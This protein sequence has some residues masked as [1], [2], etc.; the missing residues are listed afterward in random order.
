MGHSRIGDKEVDILI[1]I[2]E[3]L[4]ELRTRYKMTQSEVADELAKDGFTTTRH[5]ISRWENGINNPNIEQFLGL[6]RLFG[7]KDVYRTFGQGDLTEADVSLNAKRALNE[8]SALNQEGIAKLA[9]FRQLLIDSGKYSPKANNIRL[10][11]GRKAPLYSIGVSAGTG[12]FLDSD[13]YEMIDVPDEVPLCANFALHVTGDSM[14]PT[15]HDGDILWV[16]QQPTL[17]NGEIGIFYLDGNAYVKEFS[18]T[19][20]GVCLVSHNSQ[21]P[22][23]AIHEHNDAKIYGKVVYPVI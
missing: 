18:V 22:P 17:Q 16:Q 1:K 7:V 21:Y 23:I 3:T 8:E 4:C 6:C 2:G 10:F 13:D 19:E 11:P 15:L 9:E 5:Q 20:Q 14:E 12:Q